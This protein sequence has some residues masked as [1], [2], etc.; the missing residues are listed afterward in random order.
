MWESDYLESILP[1]FDDPGVGLAYSNATILGHPGGHTDY[2]G[3]PGVHPMHDF[4]KLAEQNPIPSPTATMRAAAVRAVGG[5]ARWLRQAED[6]HLYMKLARAGWR[7]AYVHR[8]L[9][10]YR[11]PQP[12]RGMSY[13]PR[14]H[15]L[16]EL[17]M[18]ASFVAAHPRTPGP[19][20]QV[21]TRLRREAATARAVTR[22]ELPDPPPGRPRIYVEPGSHA[23]LNLGDIAM[24]QVCV[25]R[26]E[27][28]LPGAS[29]GVVTGSPERL[30]HHVPS[31]EPIPAGGTYE[32]F[33]A[34][35][36]GG[37]YSPL[38]GR[39]RGLLRRASDLALRAGPRATR[40]A[41]RAEMLAREPLPPEV[42]E[43]LSWLLGADA[44]VVSGRGGLTDAFPADALRLLGAL[45][46][47]GG[48]GATGAMVGQ[49]VG[50][51]RDERLLAAA[52]QVLPRLELIAVRERLLA[53]RLLESLGVPRERILVTGDD[54][55][56]LA[57]RLRPGAPS[58]TGIGA[59]VR[60]SRYSG[61]ERAG[62][63]ALGEVL[64]HAAARHGS[65]LMPIP[66]SLYPHESDV[67]ALTRLLGVRGEEPSGPREVI[68]RAGRC[69]VVVAGSY[70]AGVFALA[71]GVPVVGVSASP[72]YDGK[73]EGLADLYPRGCTVISLAEP[74]F[75]ERLAAAIDEAW[76]AAPRLREELLAAT[77]RQIE[78]AR[79]A[80][81][82]LAAAISP[83]VHADRR[84]AN[85]APVS[86]ERATVGAS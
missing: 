49:G 12:E 6:Y 68:E 70:H 21:R 35:W 29:I 54:A 26:L 25:E 41:L 52:R 34:R 74:S 69:R 48:L 22:T 4:P 63:T 77:E 78:A 66:I 60:I 13:E 11:W 14:R 75:R 50:P 64:A 86:G 30:A 84:S 1:C 23:V 51:A 45:R 71:Q 28:L 80:Y 27:A 53:P 62:A 31:V 61:V 39:S 2:I 38:L 16:W 67:A 81:A 83:G 79:E 72:Y 19:R 76:E 17:A 57:H 56:E 40:A 32:W 24:L 18:F 37:A 5:Y 47:A 82:R 58:P 42:R 36:D 9:A 20:R 73:L 33:G 43:S 85:G 65:E 10:R 46:I 3:D 59:S 55:L 44:V 15:E 8:R 7:F